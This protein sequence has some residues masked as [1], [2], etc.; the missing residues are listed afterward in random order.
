M[1]DIIKRK[2]ERWDGDSW[3]GLLLWLL[4]AGILFV[5]LSL[6]TADKMVRCYYLQSSYTSAGISYQIKS[7]I[8]YATDMTAFSSPKYKETMEVFKALPQCPPED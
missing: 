3:F 6:V 1:W 2:A 4:L 5:L 8:D 7:D